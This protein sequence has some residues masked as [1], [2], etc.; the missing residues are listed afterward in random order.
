MIVDALLAPRTAF[1]TS[2]T[3]R[4]T[5]IEPAT[6]GSTGELRR[7]EFSTLKLYRVAVD[8]EAFRFARGG[9][10]PPHIARTTRSLACTR[11]NRC[12]PNLSQKDRDGAVSPLGTLIDNV[13]IVRYNITW[14]EGASRCRQGRRFACPFRPLF[15]DLS[16]PVEPSSVYGFQDDLSL[17]RIIRS[18]NWAPCQPLPTPTIPAAYSPFSTL[19]T[20]R[21]STN[22]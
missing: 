12:C 7:P 5:G 19:A 15:C 16:H 6:T 22:A 4:A 10:L 8:R 17:P 2:S 21:R 1:L 9:K 14:P 13:A 3:A 18:S 11:V 20:G